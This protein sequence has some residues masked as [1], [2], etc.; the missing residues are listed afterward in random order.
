MKF[1]SGGFGMK[2]T[3]LGAAV[4]AAALGWATPSQADPIIFDTNGT[5]FGGAII[6]NLFDWLPGNSLVIEQP[7]DKATILFQANLG[8]ITKAGTDYVNGSNGYYYTAV[9]GFGVDVSTVGGDST[10][11]FDAT[12]TTNFFKIYVT[13][14]PTTPDG[15]SDLSGS[16]FVCGKEIL[17]ATAIGDG[18]SSINHLSTLGGALDQFD[19]GLGGP[20]DNYPGILTLTGTGSTKLNAV[21]NSFDSDYFK[22]LVAGTTLAFT[23]TSQI[24]PYNQANPS[25]KFSNDG[26]TDANELGVDP[27]GV[28]GV[29]SINGLCVGPDGTTPLAVCKIVAQSDANTAFNGVA[30]VP[31]PATMTL[32]GLGLLGS[33]AARRR[34]KKNQ[35]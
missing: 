22:N 17:S 32:F 3:L 27:T 34:Q 4:L 5:D 14:T 28:A 23:N 9:A 25:N 21:V 8:V 2:K 1:I 26:V 29:G 35:K 15:A 18:F 12:S 6:G 7:N 30:P 13:T 20:I 31:E 24:D 11:T 33:A 16:C 10:F 19:D